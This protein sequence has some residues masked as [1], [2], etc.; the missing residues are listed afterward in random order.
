MAFKEGKRQNEVHIGIQELRKRVVDTY[1]K[2]P[3]GGW[4]SFR[5]GTL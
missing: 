1:G 4:G 5:F 2:L 3:A